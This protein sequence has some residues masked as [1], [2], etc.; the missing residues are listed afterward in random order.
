VIDVVEEPPYVKEEDTRLEASP[1]CAL[2]IVQEGEARVQA[3][4]VGATP[5][6]IGVAD[7]SSLRQAKD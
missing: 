4:G 3:R 7:D 6:L 2:D 5:E 1:V